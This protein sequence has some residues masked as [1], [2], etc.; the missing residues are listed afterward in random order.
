M[1]QHL[2]SSKSELIT[3]LGTEVKWKRAAKILDRLVTWRLI[4]YSYCYVI[5]V[6]YNSHKLIMVVRPY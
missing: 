3:Q 6:G 5:K 1:W 4:P 2:L